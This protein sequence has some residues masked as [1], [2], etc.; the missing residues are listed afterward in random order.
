MLRSKL[1]TERSD[2]PRWASATAEIGSLFAKTT[3]RGV[4]ERLGF[5]APLHWK[6]WRWHMGL[7]ETYVRRIFCSY[8]DCTIKFIQN[9][10]RDPKFRQV[11]LFI[12]GG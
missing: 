11:S 2:V 6:R 3:G 7:L 12:L 8:I 4:S 10:R 1:I 9:C 5:S